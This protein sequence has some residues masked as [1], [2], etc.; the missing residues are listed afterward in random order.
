MP[1]IVGKHVSLDAT[2]VMA[3]KV[4]YLASSSGEKLRV[5]PSAA[6]LKPAYRAWL[7]RLVMVA[8]T[9]EVR[10]RQ[11]SLSHWLDAC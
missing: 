8:A 1:G 4:I 6:A 3:L 5:K 2:G 9:E 11:P 10:M 7:R